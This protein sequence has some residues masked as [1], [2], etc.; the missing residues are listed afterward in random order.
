MEGHL[1]FNAK[2]WVLLAAVVVVLIAILVV[3]IMS[4]GKVLAKHDGNGYVHNFGDAPP[5]CT[6]KARYNWRVAAA[7][8][9]S[10][11][12][13]VSHPLTDHKGSTYVR[14]KNRYD[15]DNKYA[16]DNDLSSGWIDDPYNPGKRINGRDHNED[17][18]LDDGSTARVVG[19]WVKNQGVNWGSAGWRSSS[20]SA[21]STTTIDVN[22]S[23]K[24]CVEQK[25][26]MSWLNGGNGDWQYWYVLSPK[27]TRH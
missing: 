19:Y 22:Q 11:P 27:V 3:G 8:L 1:R 18:S 25:V 15:T 26:W 5:G 9:A 6:S 23:A 13:V 4:G 21:I 16:G 14:P 12:G 17:R 2:F 20:S 7:E 10:G 24:A